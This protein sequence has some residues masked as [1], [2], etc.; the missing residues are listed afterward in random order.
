MLVRDAFF[1]GPDS[2]YD[3][4]IL[5]HQLPNKEEAVKTLIGA[6][7]R[8]ATIPDLEGILENQQ[9]PDLWSEYASLG[10][11]ESEI[12]IERHPEIAVQLADS[13]LYNTPE[14]ILPMLFDQAQGDDRSL[15]NALNHPLRKIQDWATGVSPVDVNV[16]HLRKILVQAAE[17]WWRK[18]HVSDIAIRAMCIALNPG[19]D[20]TRT[21]PG[22]GR[23]VTFTSGLLRDN[24]LG[25]PR[26]GN[27]L[28]KR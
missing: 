14:L 4:R 7:A 11:R 13:V 28:R 12:V 5:F 27:L 6:R 25:C 26:I 2:V 1:G 19:F 20:T 23:T 17:F 16:L 21:D 3:Y 24:E 9:S 18:S 10:P 22:R 15:H 8:G